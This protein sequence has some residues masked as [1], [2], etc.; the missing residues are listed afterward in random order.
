MTLTEEID[1]SWTEFLARAEMMRPAPRPQVRALMAQ[2]IT[3]LMAIAAR[4][5]RLESDCREDRRFVSTS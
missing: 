5:D 3:S 4:V 1:R 2:T